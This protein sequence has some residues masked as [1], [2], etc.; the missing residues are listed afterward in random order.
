MWAKLNLC[1]GAV[2]ARSRASPSRCE[3]RFA[4]Q[5]ACGFRPDRRCF[6]PT[7]A[8]L[9]QAEGARPFCRRVRPGFWPPSKADEKKPCDFRPPARRAGAGTGFAGAGGRFWGQ[10]PWTRP[11]R[12]FRFLRRALVLPS[13]SFLSVSARPVAGCA[14]PVSAR[15][16]RG[17]ASRAVSF[18]TSSAWSARTT[19]VVFRQR[20]AHFCRSLRNSSYIVSIV[21]RFP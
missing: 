7:G 13:T 20:D 8:S 4:G 18:N 11:A 9:R 3:S 15:P 21:A 19:L 10:P 1:R 14:V 17:Q 6:I 16:L 5:A 2:G 12:A